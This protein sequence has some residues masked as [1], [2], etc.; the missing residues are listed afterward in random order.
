MVWRVAITTETKLR[1]YPL[2]IWFK[3]LCVRTCDTYQ[4]TDWITKVLVC[5]LSACRLYAAHGY[6]VSRSV[7]MHCAHEDKIVIKPLQNQPVF[8]GVCIKA[9]ITVVPQWLTLLWG[10]WNDPVA[11]NGSKLVNTDWRRLGCKSSTNNEATMRAFL[12]KRRKFNG[13][14]NYTAA[15]YHSYQQPAVGE[16]WAAF[17]L[18]KAKNLLKN[19]FPNSTIDSPNDFSGVGVKA[20]GQGDL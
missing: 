11:R 7:C 9:V 19:C 6:P 10:F 1:I 12:K 2:Q 15:I 18:H 20:T 3:Y 17:M 4:S 16:E 5:R 13:K 14:C 8:C